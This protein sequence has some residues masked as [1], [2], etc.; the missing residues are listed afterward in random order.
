MPG[1]A[2]ARLITATPFAVLQ[3]GTARPAIHA[4]RSTG[5]EGGCRRREEDDSLG[6]LGGLAK[7]AERDSAILHQ[8]GDGIVPFLAVSLL[9]RLQETAGAP[10]ERCPDR[11]WADGVDSHPGPVC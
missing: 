4:Q 11:P 9:N 7:A 1:L 5:D 10:P 2:P 3:G 8:R 6:Y